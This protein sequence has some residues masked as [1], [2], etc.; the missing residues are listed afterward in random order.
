MPS[1]ATS[2]L[3]LAHPARAVPAPQT[4]RVDEEHVLDVPLALTDYEETLA[5][6]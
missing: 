1:R 5:W 3:A 6:V 2:H 4:P